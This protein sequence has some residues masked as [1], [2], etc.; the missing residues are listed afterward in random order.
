MT[1]TALPKIL[2]ATPRFLFPLDTGGQIRSA[3]ILRAAHGTLLDVTLMSPA[4][5]EELHTYAD[6][7]QGVCNRFIP[8][9]PRWQHPFIRWIGRCISLLG[10][11]P[12]SVATDISPSFQKLLRQQRAL[13]VHC[14][15]VCDFLHLAINYDPVP[16]HIPVVLFTHN[17]EQEIF[18]R[19]MELATH[20]W[21]R[22]LW[23]NQYQKM[24]RLEQ[25]LLPRFPRVLTVS[26]RDSQFFLKDAHHPD[27]RTIPTG[28]DFERLPWHPPAESQEIIF[29]GSMDAHQNIEGVQWFLRDIWPLLLQRIPKAQ[30]RIIGRHPPRS[31]T[32]AYEYDTQVMFTGWVDDVVRVSRNGCVFAVPLRVGSGTRIKIYEA[33]ALGLPVVSTTI[34]AEGLDLE[35]GTHYLRADT[36]EDFAQSLA[37]LLSNREECL[38]L[39]VR[40]RKQVENCCGWRH[41]AEVL[42][43]A[44]IKPLGT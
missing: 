27:V 9:E 41:A 44:C 12:V 14:A 10:P 42:R 13:G 17:V 25:T 2:F 26:D 15:E 16:T 1:D 20:W 32:S 38:N 8:Y 35:P 39:S 28:V 23:N 4:T 21:Q 22:L 5:P 30:V 33:M 31:L 7:L 37:S 6:E 3:K 36:P 18:H 29:M 11:L 19:R 43:D 34:G 40:A 24:R